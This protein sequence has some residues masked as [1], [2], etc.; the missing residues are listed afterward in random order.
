MVKIKSGWQKLPLS[1]KITGFTSLLVL[2]AVLSLTFLSVY[3]EK[4]NFHEELETQAELLLEIIPRTL[5]DQLYRMELDELIQTARIAVKN[6][7]ITFIII[8]D[9]QGVVLADSRRAAPAY[10]QASDPLGITLIQWKETQPYKD[11]QKDQL[12]AGQPIILGN[13]AIGAVAVGIST[14][15]LNSKIIQLTR[16]NVLAAILILGFGIGST[17]IFSLQIIEFL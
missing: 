7:N 13:Q 5:H 4:T 12:V 11:W 2:V 1:G 9:S 16:Q 10:A 3:R 6:E 17:I 15:S 8:Y 14:E